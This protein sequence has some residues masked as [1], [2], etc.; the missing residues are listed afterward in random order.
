MYISNIK[1]CNFRNFSSKS[2]SIKFNDG[3]NV[4]I[5]HNNAGKTNIIKAL[6]LIFGAN[7]SRR[8]TI[9]DF[10]KGLTLDDMKKE[11]PR[12]TIEVEIQ[13]SRSTDNEKEDD[14]IIIAD[15]LTELEDNY[16]AKLTY[17]FFLP[18]KKEDEFTTAINKICDDNKGAALNKAW[19]ILEYDF[20]R[21]Y[22]S[23]IWGG[24][25]DLRQVAESESLAKFDFQFLDAVRDVEKDLLS[26][27]KTILKEVFSFFLDYD[28][29]KNGDK[30][31][32]E[33]TEDINKK[34]ER[35][36]NQ[37][38]GLIK[39]DLEPRFKEG[40]DNILSYT[41]ETGAS[42]RNSELEFKG[43]ITEL[44]LLTALKLIVKDKT[45]IEIPIT[46]NGL[47]Y[48]NLIFMSILLAKM[49]VDCDSDYL[50]YNAKL[51]PILAIEEPEAHLHPSM[52][53]KFL[54]FLEKEIANQKVRQIFITTHSTHITSA[55]TLDELICLYKKNKDGLTV[56]GYPGKVFDEG[57][58][59]YS[60]EDLVSKKYV[61]RFLD[62]TKS[63]MLF[64]DRVLLVE[65]LAEQLLLPVF[66]EIEGYSLEDHHV[67]VVSIGGRYF[68]HFLKLFDKE[69]RKSA[70]PK[71]V[72]I[73]TDRDPERKEKN[74][75]KN[76]N[77]FTPCYPF[78]Y[79]LDTISYDYRYNGM[80]KSL[81]DKFSSQSQIHL[82]F[83]EKGKTLEYDL[84]YDNPTN[85]V[86]LTDSVANKKELESL[87][88]SYKENK[89]DTMKGSVSS[90][91]E[92]KR[93]IKALKE[94]NLDEKKKA[95]SLIAARYLNSISKGEN[96]LELAAALKDS[97]Y[98][99]TQKQD[100][101]VI[102]SYIKEAIKEICKD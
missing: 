8:L 63:D 5:G 74:A 66:A 59:K 34:K 93:I 43:S 20:L 31:K 73:I 4:I 9:D 56:I 72:V 49:Q 32:A 54:K 51:F 22:I 13:K 23:R 69:N 99:K 37:I 79:E 81:I 26:G 60:K 19:S 98:M 6:S 33:I 11:S 88:D 52:Q 53:F 101:L 38:I 12:V 90:S 28:I 86:L 64:S 82:F 48:N 50:D 96:A 71:K 14:L 87:M 94:S 55:V 35:F 3:I 25:S 100:K 47:G 27:H 18:K 45:G 30:S 62:A 65:G 21:Y 85:K 68:N 80:I 17:E 42:F 102:P 41:K 58:S 7:I 77:N 91:K 15:W 40:K 92:N 39:S 2:E 97:L 57:G 89:Y 1:I 61:Q 29:K 76:N 24:N 44:D 75:R 16:K 10:Y 36:H 46:H 95:C 78:E 83:N 70:L 84:A 67:S